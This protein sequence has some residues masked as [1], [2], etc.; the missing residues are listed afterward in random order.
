MAERQRSFR[1]M[2]P[3]L[4]GSLT[5]GAQWR[6]GMT[7]L[8]E[9]EMALSKERALTQEQR[10]WQEDQRRKRWLDFGPHGLGGEGGREPSIS[11]QVLDYVSMWPGNIARKGLQTGIWDRVPA[12]IKKRIKRQ[13][14]EESEIRPDAEVLSGDKMDMIPAVDKRGYNTDF[15]GRYGRGRQD[16]IRTKPKSRL[17][18]PRTAGD[19]S[20]DLG[21]RLLEYLRDLDNKKLKDVR[22]QIRDWPGEEML[23]I[24]T[25]KDWD[26]IEGRRRDPERL[27]QAEA[28]RQARFRSINEAISKTIDEPSNFDKLSDLVGRT[29]GRKKSKDF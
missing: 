28:A 26:R 16:D 13:M 12:K 14:K 27:A 6:R 18:E 17:D 22:N 2:F 23:V 25:P 1:D 10:K 7:S 3:D 29:F 21:G 19:H 9:K 5:Q 20:L 8:S 4:M 24:K 15:S 11:S